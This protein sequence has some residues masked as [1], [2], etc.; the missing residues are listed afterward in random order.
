MLMLRSREIC[1]A[2]CPPPNRVN[3]DTFRMAM[4]P[5]PGQVAP[6]AHP[7]AGEGP[8]DGAC[9]AQPKKKRVGR[10]FDLADRVIS[11]HGS[12]SESHNLQGIRIDTF[13]TT[14]TVYETFCQPLTS[15]PSLDTPAANTDFSQIPRLSCHPKEPPV[16]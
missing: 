7:H 16:G 14:G 10:K 8:E 4:A 15:Y 6:N 13:V 1:R 11:L 3:A 2:V 5:P 12:Q 9:P